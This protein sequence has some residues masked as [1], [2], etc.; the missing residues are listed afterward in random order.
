MLDRVEARRCHYRL[1]LWVSSCPTSCLREQAGHATRR[2]HVKALQSLKSGGSENP[3][4]T[5]QK[6]DGL[7]GSLVEHLAYAGGHVL[8]AQNAR[9]S[10]PDAPGLL[11]DPA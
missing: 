5:S 7:Y 2:L 6:K 8:R 4:L 1:R 11:Q 10:R 3:C 9:D